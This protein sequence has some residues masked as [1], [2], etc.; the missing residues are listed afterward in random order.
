MAGGEIERVT[1]GLG[2]NLGGAAAAAFTT[3]MRA[4]LGLAA[5][6]LLLGAASIL[7]GSRPPAAADTAPDP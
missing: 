1:A 2:N 7:T 5:I 3:G 4:G 6:G